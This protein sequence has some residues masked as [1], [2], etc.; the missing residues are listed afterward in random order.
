M[1][2]PDNVTPL[3]SP[4]PRPSVATTGRRIVTA[5]ASEIEAKVVEWWEDC[6]IPR[7]ALSLIAGREGLGKSTV[8]VDFAARETQQ[9]GVVLY[10]DSEDSRTH[11]IRPRLEAAGA[12]LDR[13]HFLTVLDDEDGEE[14]E[15]SLSLPR[16]FAL[17]RQVVE[18][19]GVTFIVL[20]AA[21][22]F[23]DQELKSN[24]DRDIRRYLEPFRKLAEDFNLVV[25]GIVHFGKRD[26]IDSGKL[27]LGSIA[28]SQ[29]ARSVLSMAH[30]KETD[31]LV[32]TNSKGNLAPRRRSEKLAVVSRPL[33]IDNITTSVGG[34]EWL[35]ESDVEATDLLSQESGSKLDDLGEG[36]NR[37]VDALVEHGPGRPKE[38]AERINEDSKKVSTWLGRA[39]KHGLVTRA[40]TRGTWVAR[41]GQPSETNTDD[42][43]TEP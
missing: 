19:L 38:I 42:T 4:P 20:D 33:T 29:V 14:F 18:Q 23:I 17:L 16:D 35:G 41:I 13:V 40:D 37:V 26:S 8:T 3:P 11:T 25:V 28:W 31:Q 22:S 5:R 10:L 24:Q 36:V 32:I 7:A 2:L 34:I 6:W 39:E 43:N 1:K 9:G 27:I 15:S 12:D 21:S 30:N